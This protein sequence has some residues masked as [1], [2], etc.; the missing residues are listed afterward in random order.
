MPQKEGY[1]RMILSQIIYGNNPRDSGDVW[2][3]RATDEKW[4]P[5]QRLQSA[6]WKKKKIPADL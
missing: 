1:P 6:K 2:N 4:S 5:T 3:G